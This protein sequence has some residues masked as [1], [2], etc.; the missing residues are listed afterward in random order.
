MVLV[1][2]VGRPRLHL[3]LQDAE[4]EV[5]GLD[6]L[7]TF[8]SGLQLGVEPLEVFSPEIHQSFARLPIEGFVGAEQ[9]PVL[10]LLHS[11]HEEVRDPKSQKQ[12]ASALL[13][14]AMILAQL[15]EVIDICMPWLQVHGEGSFAL[16]TALIHVARRL[17]E[18]PQHGH[19]AV[20]VAVGAA[21][22]G[23]ARPDVGDGHANATS[24]FRDQCALLQGIVHPLDGV[25]LHL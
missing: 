15:N 24:R 2:H 16:A 18:V 4:P 6:G 13:L 8:A 7:A 22:V 5:L 20:A 21:D 1:Q 10:V 11:L 19:Q 17:V 14:L 12:V 25:V 9:R 3:G 23:A